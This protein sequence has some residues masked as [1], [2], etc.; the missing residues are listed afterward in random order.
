M[1][2][3]KVEFLVITKGKCKQVFIPRGYC[4]IYLQNQTDDYIE[5]NNLGDDVCIENLSPDMT[6][7]K[8]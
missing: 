8:R 5:V 1:K 7:Q 4:T 3:E 6:C 2:S